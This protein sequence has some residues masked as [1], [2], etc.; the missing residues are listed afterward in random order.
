M[1]NSS[2][3]SQRIEIR[4]TGLYFSGDTPEFTGSPSPG[5]SMSVTPSVL[6]LAPGAGQPVHV[7][8]ATAATARPGGLYGGVVFSD[9]PPAQ[10]GAVNVVT[11]QA[12]PV[13]GH[14]RG[15]TS[16]TGTIKAFVQLPP[17][18]GPVVKLQAA[19]VDTGNIDY[20]ISGSVTV[21][22]SSGVLGTAQITPRLVLPGEART[23]PIDISP[24]AAGS[25]PDGDYTATLHLIWGTAGEH[26]GQANT[27]VRFSYAPAGLGSGPV[28]PTT[29]PPTFIGRPLTHVPHTTGAATHK[30]VSAWTWF[31]RVVDLLLL[32][33][34]LILLA[35][36]MWTWEKERRRRRDEG[37]AAAKV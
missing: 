12:R 9:V 33:L 14:V 4:A 15:P 18:S 28:S 20:E 35:L 5:L 23:F 32:L 17:D 30:R 3:T 10:A 16:D 26:S 21:L 29:R 2:S 13:I 31:V 11:A 25:V 22:G 8:V 24:S 34:A 37:R 6:L 7:S 1:T 27:A 19:F 36:A